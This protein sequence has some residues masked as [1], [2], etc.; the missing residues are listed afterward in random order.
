MII[1]EL[2]HYQLPAGAED[3]DVDWD[4]VNGVR[5]GVFSTKAL[6]EAAIE[7]RRDKEGF[8]DWPHGWRIW[9][10]ELDEA[11]FEDGFPGWDGPEPEPSIRP[12]L[13]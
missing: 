3:E 4:E 8:C 11:G 12:K 10:S 13:H 9:D 6:A 5:I 1:F 7:A 2:W